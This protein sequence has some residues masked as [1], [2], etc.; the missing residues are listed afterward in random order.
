MLSEC[1]GVE[2]QKPNDWLGKNE[3]PEM[4]QFGNESSA[5]KAA[6]VMLV[7]VDDDELDALEDAVP[8]SRYQVYSANS[9]AKAM[10]R[11]DES[12]D[13]IVTGLDLG[14][15]TAIQF[16]THWREVSP[17]TR[18][19][20]VAPGS[21][22]DECV[23]ALQAGANDCVRL[24]LNP[25]ELQIRV[26][27]AVEQRLLE[28]RLYELARKP[29]SKSGPTTFNGKKL[30]EMEREAIEAALEAYH[31]NRT[32]AADAL[33]ISVRTLQRKIK[34][35]GLAPPRDGRSAAY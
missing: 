1:V 22:E 4:E 27:R 15:N 5:K 3:G 19:I 2:Q 20:V 11:I 21:N 9:V 26:C 13:V 16:M 29:V 24:P 28:Q 34:A 32:H 25:E 12:V 30:H 8:E 7:A 35:W 17:D 33:G 18:F 14:N 10:E 6:S 31:G 23:K